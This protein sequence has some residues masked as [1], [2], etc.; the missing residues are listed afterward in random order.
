ML[1]M[2][3]SVIWSMST[4]CGVGAAGG[5]LGVETVAAGVAASLATVVSL[6]SARV[7]VRGA[8]ENGASGISTV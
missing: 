4:A 3:V 8:V 5:A 2:T 7:T 1:S 6:S